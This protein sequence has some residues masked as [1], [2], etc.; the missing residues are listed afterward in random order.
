MAGSHLWRHALFSFHAGPAIRHQ[1]DDAMARQ[2]S[3]GPAGMRGGVPPV[4]VL[5]WV[6]G[7]WAAALQGTYCARAQGQGQR[8][9]FM[10]QVA[11]NDLELKPTRLDGER[12][13]PDGRLIAKL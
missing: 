1:G 13:S 5:A 4:A 8:A 7:G 11:V 10:F 9:R 2:S 6:V 3:M 12:L